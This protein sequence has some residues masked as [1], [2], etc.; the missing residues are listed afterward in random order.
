VLCDLGH[1]PGPH[2]NLVV[3]VAVDPTV[4]DD[5]ALTAVRMLVVRHEA[6]RTVYENRGDLDLWATTLGE[7]A[8]EAWLVHTDETDIRR[9]VGDTVRRLR[10]RLFDLE[11][12]LPLRA[13]IVRSAEAVHIALVMSLVAVDGWSL[14][15]IRDELLALLRDPACATLP[16]VD[17]QP[18]DEGAYAR[19]DSGHRALARALVH[20]RH[21]LDRAPVATPRCEQTAYPRYWHATFDSPAVARLVHAIAARHQVAVS[22]VVLGALAKLLG[23]HDNT[24]HCWLFAVASNRYKKRL[25]QTVGHFS[26]PVPLEFNLGQGGLAEVVSGAHVALLSAARHGSVDP[27]QVR[28]LTEET[29]RR[30]GETLELGVTFNFHRSPRPEHV[31]DLDAAQLNTLLAESKFGWRDMAVSENMTFYAHVW[32]TWPVARL[33]FWIDTAYISR[34]QMAA[35]TLR[36]EDLLVHMAW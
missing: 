10:E 14:D 1:Q 20:W 31:P 2:L 16:T 13:T 32:R 15:I 6:L 7:G 22:A 30:R 4:S 12:D 28:Q 11:H 18:I 8:V 23:E 3:D 35:L 34:S 17:W 24:T 21:Q 9:V 26:Q 36:L 19:S 5:A 25:Q 27:A 33:S 29:V